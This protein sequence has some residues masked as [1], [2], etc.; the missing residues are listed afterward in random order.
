MP[1]SCGTVSSQ[2]SRA[3]ASLRVPL[4]LWSASASWVSFLQVLVPLSPRQARPHSDTFRAERKPADVGITPGRQQP[5]RAC[6]SPSLPLPMDKARLLGLTQPSCRLRALSCVS[7][8]LSS[9]C[10]GREK[11]LTVRNRLRELGRLPG[12]PGEPVVQ[13][14]LRVSAGEAPVL[15]KPVF[16]PT[17]LFLTREAHCGECLLL[18]QVHRL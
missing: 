12:A 6:D 2:K 14:Q 18:P 10:A 5:W 9:K 7:A 3:D 17:G 8:V 15:G 16:C 1:R 11:R 13:L 4:G